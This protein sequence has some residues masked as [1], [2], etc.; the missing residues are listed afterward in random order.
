MWSKR[1][2]NKLA[3][4]NCRN[5][6]SKKGTRFCLSLLVC[7]CYYHGGRNFCE[8]KCSKLFRCL[9]KNFSFLFAQVWLKFKGCS[10]CTRRHNTYMTMSKA[11]YMRKFLIYFFDE[12]FCF[13]PLSLFAFLSHR[14]HFFDTFTGQ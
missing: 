12:G 11:S 14:I 5:K 1:R 3:I 9:Y 6:F 2:Y 7:F 8:Y 4:T 10:T 13:S